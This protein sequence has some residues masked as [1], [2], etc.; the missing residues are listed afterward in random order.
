MAR[1]NFLADIKINRNSPA[2]EAVLSSPLLDPILRDKAVELV[3]MYQARVG[4]KTRKLHDSAAA[5]LRRGGHNSDRIIAAVTIADESVQSTWKGQPFYYGEYHEEGTKKKG[6]NY[7]SVNGRRGYHELRE[8]ANEM[9]GT[10]WSG[11]P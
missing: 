3:R 6:R 10:T 5:E 4:K 7:R 8:V 2:Y 9:R 1:D 11:R